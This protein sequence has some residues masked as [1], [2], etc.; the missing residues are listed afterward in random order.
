MSW[1]LHLFLFTDCIEC[2]EYGDSIVKSDYG[3][4]IIFIPFSGFISIIDAG[5]NYKRYPL[6]ESRIDEHL[7]LLLDSYGMKVNILNINEDYYESFSNYYNELVENL[8]YNYG[9]P[10]NWNLKIQFR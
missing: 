1:I 6:T 9:N 7:K 10:L 3:N 4:E 2:L 8:L 5:E